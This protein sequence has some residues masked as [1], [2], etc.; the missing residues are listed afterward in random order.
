MKKFVTT[1]YEIK[2][3]QLHHRS[4]TFAGITDLHNVRYGSDNQPV[5]QAMKKIRP[6]AILI[7]GDLVLG[8]KGESLEPARQFLQE[9]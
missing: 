7:A 4:L 5:L 1:K 2:T 8:K 6:D 3:N 9:L